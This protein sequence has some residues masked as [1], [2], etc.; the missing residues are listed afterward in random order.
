[1]SVT[2]APSAVK[3]AISG[4]SRYPLVVPRGPE[5]P[6]PLNG[7]SK[8][9]QPRPM[10]GSDDGEILEATR[11]VPPLLRLFEVGQTLPLQCRGARQVTTAIGHTCEVAHREAEQPVIA[12]LAECR[13]GR[14]IEPRRLNFVA[15]GHRQIASVDLGE[16][17]TPSIGTGLEVLQAFQ[18][19]GAGRHHV[20]LIYGHRTQKPLGVVEVSRGVQIAPQVD[21]LH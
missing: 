8:A 5:S 16:A 1:M 14:L 17:V 21:T 2:A 6:G 10:G 9:A 3:A 4:K 18:D 7:L 19:V 15:L 13:D 20:I 11:E 12:H